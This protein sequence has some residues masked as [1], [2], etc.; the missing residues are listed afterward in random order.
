[1]Q[2]ESFIHQP[3]LFSKHKH[4]PLTD[5]QTSAYDNLLAI[6]DTLHFWIFFHICVHPISNI[7]LQTR[8]AAG[9]RCTLLGL[10]SLCILLFALQLNEF[11]LFS[12]HLPLWMLKTPSL[13]Q[14]GLKTR[15]GHTFSGSLPPLLRD[16]ICR[17]FHGSSSESQEDL[18]KVGTP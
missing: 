14:S 3:I 2:V 8:G 10:S 7:T 16:N 4:Y 12:S 13:Q 18:H 6:N 15:P 9:L 11:N 1:M 17:Q 5:A